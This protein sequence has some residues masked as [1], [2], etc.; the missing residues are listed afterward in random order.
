M[1]NPNSEQNPEPFNHRLWLLLTNR[2]TLTVVVLLLA[3]LAGGAWWAWVWIHQQLAP[4][5]EDNLQ[6][7]LG[8]PVEL[9]EVDGVSFT[10][11]RFG[12][13]AIPA[14]STDPDRVTVE[15]VNVRFSPWQLLLNR[16]L[17]LNITLLE[18]D[19]YVE[20]S[21]D[22]QWIS[23]RLQD[24]EG[25]GFIT[26]DL[27]SIRFEDA[28]VVL[29]PI[30]RPGLPEGPVTLQE[31]DGVAQFLEQDNQRIAFE[32]EGEFARGGSLEI[33]GETRPG[34]Q[35]TNLMVQA[36]NV[37]A[38][39]LSRLVE[40]PITLQAGLVSGNL[41]VALRPE[42]QPSI[43]GT[44]SL[45]NVTA[46]IENI[47]QRFIDADGRLRFQ[48]EAIALENLNTRYGQVPATV[49]GVVNLETGY[50]L[51]GR[52]RSV[53]VENLLETL[54]VDSPI[55][56]SGTVRAE[57]Q[58]EG[59][60]RE[61]ILS[62]EVRTIN[63]AQIDQVAFR[64]IRSSFQASFTG[65][66]P[67]IVFPQIRAVPQAGGQVVG[68]GGLQFGEQN[69]TAFTFRANEVP[70]DA[71]AELYDVSPGIRIGDVSAV[72][73]LSGSSGN[74]QT[75]VQ[76]RAPEATYPGR[77]EVVITN[78]GTILLRDAAFTVAGGTV[79]AR[80]RYDQG[81]FQAVVD[82]AQVRLNQFAEGLRGRLSGSLS[83][84][85][86][87][88]N[89][90]DIR[91]QGRL[92]F[93]EGL[94]LIEQPLTAQ[95]RWNGEQVIVQQATAPG[96]NA[97]GAIAVQLEGAA[98][99]QIAGLNLNVQA[100]GYS[101]QAFD[102]PN[103]IALAGQADFTGRV[104]GTPEAPNAIGD[105]RL[106]NL[107]VNGVAFDPIL[108]GDLSYRAGAQ[109]QLNVTGT[110]DR[111]AL[112]LGPDNLPTSFF[113]RRD[114]AIATGR[115]EGDTLLVNLQDFPVAVLQNLLPGDALNIGPIAGDLSGAL[116]VNLDDFSAEGEVAIANPRI[117]RVTGDLFRGRFTYADG[118]A[119]LTEGEFLQG[120]SRIA[121]S[122][123]FDPGAAQP[124]DFRI[125]FDQARIENVLQT[126]SLFGFED[127]ATGLDLPGICRCCSA[128]PHSAFRQFTSD[129]TATTFR[130]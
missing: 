107:L 57:L 43:T 63:T 47:P 72:A 31:I 97:S 103:N 19:A 115:S 32:L 95:V 109:T 62:G 10:G 59:P 5:V 38:A 52:V 49:N 16:T 112:T 35:Q 127:F 125:S 39:N 76:F 55:P 14:T 80:G 48:G 128:Q 53:S 25:A 106:R 22:G 126:L 124:I 68:E 70:G 90:A 46:Q 130:D 85:G 67:E 108:T 120:E 118:A 29:V 66:N 91:A 8:R 60:L 89:L 111:I 51:V 27:E 113:V 42:Q 9:G 50:D 58:V 65:E 26:T 86:D 12:E 21:P 78:E 88:F 96:L 82:A 1:T 3:G 92:R 94:A 74:L 17:Q 2:I 69:T 45:E 100:Q 129:P 20:Q 81:E 28:N 24:Q 71:I 98:A 73:R 34:A 40:L 44:A 114:Q 61:P 77:G 110:Q 99:P 33:M 83:L 23:T 93:S 79:E 15:G 101:L 30:P 36:Q 104:T 87:S 75:V 119:Q 123:G 6:Q 122:G 54:N 84:S 56:L 4:L 11:L 121:L 7:L 105:L 64:S 37:P 41:D 18:P 116:A 117:G 102:L 13:S